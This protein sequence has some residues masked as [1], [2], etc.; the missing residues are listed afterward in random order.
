MSAKNSKIRLS[1]SCLLICT[2]TKRS[3]LRFEEVFG[4][5]DAD[6]IN[7]NLALLGQHAETRV[8]VQFPGI[9]LPENEQKF[10]KRNVAVVVFVD[11]LK[12]KLAFV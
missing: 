11:L 4:S 6:L 5:T 9:E 7:I 10:A 3:N 8:L 1:Q 2:L 12:M